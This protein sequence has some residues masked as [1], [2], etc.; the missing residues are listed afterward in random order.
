MTETEVMNQ[1]KKATD[2]K[3][4][5]FI[6]EKGYVVTKNENEGLKVKTELLLTYQKLVEMDHADKLKDL[7]EYQ[8]RIGIKKDVEKDEFVKKDTKNNEYNEKDQMKKLK[9]GN[10]PAK[11]K[12]LDNKMIIEVDKNNDNW[13]KKVKMEDILVISEEFK[14]KMLEG[15][16]GDNGKEKNNKTKKSLKREA[17][18]HG[19]KSLE[20]SQQ[21]C[22][23]T[24]TNT[25]D[26]KSIIDNK[27]ESNSMWLQDQFQEPIVHTIRSMNE[28]NSKKINDLSEL[29]REVQGIECA[30]KWW[31]SSVT[32]LSKIVNMRED[33]IDNKVN[34]PLFNSGRSV[35][36]KTKKTKLESKINSYL[37]T[38]TS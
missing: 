20:N 17:L 34:T 28:A 5:E 19:L 12:E 10:V 29:S 7:K 24:G 9:A 38:I 37:S 26:I 2:S 32:K 25:L 21:N 36:S 31:S 33:S 3:T 16:K 15:Y 14:A 23:D 1:P 35:F 18:S 30:D 11:P 4:P 22:I 6:L 8:T 13:R 27:F